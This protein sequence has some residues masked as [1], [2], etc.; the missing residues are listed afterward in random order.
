MLVHTLLQPPPAYTGASALQLSKRAL[1]MGGLTALAPA[2]PP[3]EPPEPP[4]PPAPAL[5]SPP[6]SEQLAPSASA[7][8]TPA[9]SAGN[10]GDREEPSDRS[11][12][13][14]RHT[15][16]ARAQ[17]AS[18]RVFGTVLRGRVACCRSWCHRRLLRCP[19]WRCRHNAPR[20]RPAAWG[21]GTGPPRAPLAIAARV[22]IVHLSIKWGMGKIQ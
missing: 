5:P 3:P 10:E 18:R 21:G 6:S 8:A 1:G 14:H 16:R 20:R 12:G 4:P 7:S 22:L 11:M 15:A 13:S 2:E 17:P 19:S 9:S